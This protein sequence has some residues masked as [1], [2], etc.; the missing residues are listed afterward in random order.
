MNTTT[1]NSVVTYKCINGYR[2]HENITSRT[3]LASGNW[4]EGN[5]SCIKIDDDCEG[6]DCGLSA[7]VLAAIICGA[8][9]IPLSCLVAVAGCVVRL[10][11]Q[12]L[13]KSENI[14]SLTS[15]EASTLPLHHTVTNQSP[16]QQLREELR[17][18]NM[19][20]PKSQLRL[21]RV[22]GQGESGI[23]YC[24]YMKSI[25]GNEVVAVKT[26]KAL[27]AVK[28]KDRL[29]KEERRPC[30]LCHSC[31]RAMFWGML[32]S[33]G[34]LSSLQTS[35]MRR[36]KKPQRQ[37]WECA[38][39]YPKGWLTLQSSSL[40]TVTWAARNCMIDW[41]DV[42]KVSDFGL[43]EDIYS[44][45]YF[46]PKSTKG[47]EEKLPIK[48]MA[49]E[50]IETNIFNET[51]D[52]WSFGV[53]CWEVFTCGGVPYAGV[54]VTTLLSELRSG[55]R[56]DRPSNISCSD[57]IW[58]VVTSCWSASPQE[59]PRFATLVNTLTDLLDSDSNY[60]KLLG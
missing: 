7:G 41:N 60:V 16:V 11:L 35:T 53:T 20:I 42:I 29:L 54:P 3:C 26:G 19:L 5:I 56:L 8:G 28:D 49:P 52:V 40:F 59:R 34:K 33:T 38:T 31:L 6:S 46:R 57:D 32:E 25:R 24:G 12:K 43:T 48:W 23:V 21:G 15:T 36:Y 39:R 1:E 37:V 47:D 14:L 17:T 18:K 2:F 51:T 58:S 30:S 4:T 55:H 13:K 50:S 45:N 22:V 44:Y 27:L 10:R 9:F